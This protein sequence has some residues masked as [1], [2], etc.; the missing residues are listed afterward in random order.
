MKNKDLLVNLKQSKAKTSTAKQCKVRCEGTKDLTHKSHGDLK[1]TQSNAT[2]KK[3][4]QS[5]A[6]PSEVQ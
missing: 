3:A 5:K 6:K 4:K 2:Q 1:E